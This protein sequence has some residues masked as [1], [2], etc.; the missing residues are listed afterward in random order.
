MKPADLIADYEYLLA[1]LDVEGPV[2]DL[3]C[4]EGQNGMVFS[5]KG[6]SVT[7]CDKSAKA[8]ARVAQ[9]AKEN[10]VNADLWEVDLEQDN[11][12]PFLAGHYG[13]ILVF[14]YLHRP[15]MPCIRKA[16][17]KGGLL[18]YETYTVDQREY[19]RPRNPRYLLKSGEL[20]NLFSNWRIFHY[21]EGVK[22]AP[23]RAVAQL[24]CQ[25]P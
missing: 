1:D 5:M 8:L 6:F 12:N 17:R 10:G 11:V 14:R 7:F 23:E 20:L 18:F 9:T 25:K 2:L 21:F 16:L 4:G 19:G 13:I 24:V 3:A 15:L 22:Y